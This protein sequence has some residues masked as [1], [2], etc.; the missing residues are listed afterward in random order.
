MSTYNYHDSML[1]DIN[2]WFKENPEMLGAGYEPC[3]DQLWIT[4]SI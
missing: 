3:Y 4:D 2:E 1:Q